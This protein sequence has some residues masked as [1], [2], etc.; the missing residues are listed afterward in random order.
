MTCCRWHRVENID[1]NSVILKIGCIIV[2][3]A[4]SMGMAIA[5]QV[6]A[7]ISYG[8]QPLVHAVPS[9]VLPRRFRPVAQAAVNVAAALGSIFGLLVGG[10]L[11]RHNP[12][13]FRTYWY[14]DAGLFAAAA[15]AVAILYNPPPRELQTV[16]THREKFARLDWVGFVLLSGG[17]LLFCMSLVWSQNPYAW[18]NAHILA[19]F[20]IGILL[21]LMLIVYELRFKKDGIFHHALFQRGRNFGI[22]LGCVFV[23]GLVFFTCNN[24]FAFEVSTLYETDVL[25]VGVRYSL[26]FIAF[27]ISTC[28]TG[29]YCSRTKSVQLPA[30][31]AFILFLTFCITMATATVGSNKDVWG[32]PILFGTGLGICLNTLMTTAQLGTPPELIATA[33]GLMISVRSLGGSVGL[34]IYNAIFTHAL[35]TNLA[36]KV[37]AVVLPLGLP[38]SSIGLFIGDMT[39]GQSDALNNIPGITGP[40]IQAGGNAVLEAFSVAFRYVWITAGCFT[41]IALIAVFFIQ[42][43]RAEFNRHIDAP[44]EP[45]SDSTPKV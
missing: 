41:F 42:D 11:T 21:I 44:I 19:P 38:P 6:V 12:S 34:A 28:I 22:A 23:E 32:Y 29:Y 26:C 16:L 17:L 39:S 15:L 45:V 5:G 7:G 30:T 20:I 24:Y 1:A 25:I 10:A 13:G 37:P 3:R 18:S 8:A 14:I 35:S 2:G 33:S 31:F 9:E 43:P 36:S 40:I 4:N 27:G